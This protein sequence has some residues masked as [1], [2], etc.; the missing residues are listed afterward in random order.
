TKRANLATWFKL[1]CAIASTTKLYAAFVQALM[2]LAMVQCAIA[3]GGLAVYCLTGN[4]PMPTYYL[5]LTALASS[6]SI[7]IYLLPLSFVVSL[8][9]NHAVYLRQL[10]LKLH[11]D[12]ATTEIDPGLADYLGMLIEKIENDDDRIEYWGMELTTAKL[13]SLSVSLGSGVSFLL[14]KSVQFNWSD[15]NPCYI[16]Y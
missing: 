14:T 7:L 2:P 15:Y 9:A 12:K 6:L 10:R 13:V 1:R 4:A 5:L 16:S 11:S 8:Q 3:V